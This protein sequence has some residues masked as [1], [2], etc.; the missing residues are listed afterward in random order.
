MTDVRATQVAREIASGGPSFLR[1]TQVA[2]EIVE[3][4]LPRLPATPWIVQVN[5]TATDLW[6]DMWDQPYGNLL[7]ECLERVEIE[8]DLGWPTVQVDTCTV[9]ARDADWVIVPGRTASP[10]YPNVQFGRAAR[11]LARLADGTPMPQFY[12]EIVDYQPN[13]DGPPWYIT[14]RLESPLRRVLS[15]TVTVREF[16]AGAATVRFDDPNDSPLHLLLDAAEI[17]PANRDIEVRE[18]PA[19]T[20]AWGGQT[21][22]GA[23]LAQLAEQAKAAVACEPQYRTSVDGVD[24]QLRWFDPRSQTTPTI[25]WNW[26]LGDLQPVPQVDYAGELP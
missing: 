25:T 10:L 19:L 6:P 13:L 26:Q 11:V 17:P 23:L 24:W 22:V 18:W 4:F 3:P 2:R 5:W 15:K 16:G 21:T 8:R 7:S 14:I 20:A 12:G 9:T 1:A